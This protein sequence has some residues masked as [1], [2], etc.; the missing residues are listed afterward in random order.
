[1][2]EIR[3]DECGDWPVGWKSDGWMCQVLRIDGVDQRGRTDDHL[4]II[5]MRYKSQ[6]PAMRG[7][8]CV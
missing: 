4:Y 6:S 3:N 5:K 2:G 8:N 7:S 1:M